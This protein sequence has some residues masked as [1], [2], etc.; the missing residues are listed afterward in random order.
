[1]ALKDLQVR[2]GDVNIKVELIEK[3]DIREFQKFGKAG[4]VCSAKVKDDSGEMVLTLWNDEID[5]VKVGDKIHIVNGYVSEWQGEPQLSAGRFGKIEVV[6]K[7]EG[8]PA[9]KAEKPKPED[10]EESEE[11]EEVEAEEEEIE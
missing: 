4:R 5:S 7:G 11:P 6:E 10:P 3:G 9:G 2:Q 1:M 8:E